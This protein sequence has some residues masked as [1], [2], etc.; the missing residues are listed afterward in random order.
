MAAKRAAEQIAFILI[1][2]CISTAR[3]E[4]R[5]WSLSEASP[6]AAVPHALGLFSSAVAPCSYQSKD[7]P[8]QVIKRAHHPVNIKIQDDWK[9]R[10]SQS[11]DSHSSRR[12]LEL[13]SLLLTIYVKRKAQFNIKSTQLWE[14]MEL[15]STLCTNQKQ[16][17][18]KHL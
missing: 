3:A 15:S 2:L 8:N 1:S 7:R 14:N 12:H 16:S 13:L 5:L 6:H 18:M 11:F 17:Q 9:K 4:V 10:K